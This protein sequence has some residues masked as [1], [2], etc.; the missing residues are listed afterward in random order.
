MFMALSN[1][2]QSVSIPGQVRRPRDR[3]FVRQNVAFGQTQPLALDQPKSIAS[4]SRARWRSTGMSPVLALIGPTL[5]QA[6]SKGCM[7]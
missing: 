2:A 1:R 6:V 5:N 3:F 4:R 7:R